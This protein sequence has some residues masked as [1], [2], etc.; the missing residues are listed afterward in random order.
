MSNSVGTRDV[1]LLMPFL[2]LEWGGDLVKR[3][4]NHQ[5]REFY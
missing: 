5:G 1:P 4:P 2:V 3:K